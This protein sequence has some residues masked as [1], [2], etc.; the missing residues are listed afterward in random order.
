MD[1]VTQLIEQLEL[2][3]HPEGGFY[4]QI[5]RSSLEV[6]PRDGRQGRPALTTIYFLLPDGAHSRWHRVRSDEVWHF[7]EGAPLGLW[8]LSP[9]LERLDRITL[10]PFGD[11]RRP[12][13]V[14][15]ADAWQAAR[16][17]GAYTL[18]GCSVGPGFVF[19]DFDMM[20]QDSREA[21]R[22][23]D[24]WPEAATLL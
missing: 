2:Q 6:L 13:H 5:F 4:R 15:P 12:V 9:D 7:Y 19:E 3:P 1:R 21:A 22:V 24:R 8:Q 18:A 11:E 10:G 16:S 14:V 23:R 17:S 20:R